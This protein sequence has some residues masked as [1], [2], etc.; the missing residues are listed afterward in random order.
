MSVH[1]TAVAP[2]VEQVTRT[3][4]GAAASCGMACVANAIRDSPTLSVGATTVHAA[5]CSSGQ[6][7]TV[8]ALAYSDQPHF[9]APAAAPLTWS[10]C[11]CVTTHASIDAGATPIARSR[12]ASVAR[13]EARVHQHAAL[14]ALDQHGVAARC[15][16]RAPR[17]SRSPRSTAR[18]Y[19]G[20]ELAARSRRSASR[21]GAPS[22]RSATSRNLSAR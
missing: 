2:V 3:P 9:F 6:A 18:A 13:R 12:R 21:A 16:C 17:A 5:S 22:S 8:P 14:A 4:M 20:G 7:S 11:S 10:V 1:T 19:D 15:R